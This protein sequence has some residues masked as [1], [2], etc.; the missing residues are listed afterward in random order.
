M[1]CIEHGQDAATVEP[2]RACRRY[3][4]I[5]TDTRGRAGKP[6][7][8]ALLGHAE[9]VFRNVQRLPGSRLPTDLSGQLDQ[10]R[11]T[12]HQD[13]VATPLDLGDES[14]GRELLG[15]IIITAGA[16]QAPKLTPAVD[17]ILT[18]RARPSQQS[19]RGTV[20]AVPRRSPYDSSPRASSGSPATNQPWNRR[21]RSHTDT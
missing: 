2:R 8:G 20:S 12:G 6:H 7:R 21:P 10:A 19:A 4:L 18:A 3:Q 5:D 15:R 13:V 9:V 11:T 1:T 17:H 16:K 14:A